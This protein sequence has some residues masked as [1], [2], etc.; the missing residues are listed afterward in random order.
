MTALLELRGVTSQDL[1][2][3]MEDVCLAVAANVGASVGV[4]VGAH[5]WKL[6]WTETVTSLPFFHVLFVR[7]LPS[8]FSNEES[9]K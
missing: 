6:L 2:A 5:N 3:D 1:H 4:G 9:Q 7:R 8:R